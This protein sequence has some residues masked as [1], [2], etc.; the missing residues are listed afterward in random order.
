MI[1]QIRADNVSVDFKPNQIPHLSAKT[2]KVE[3]DFI[4]P[5]SQAAKRTYTYQL[6]GTR[7][8]LFG[9][10]LPLTIELKASEG[11]KATFF[12]LPPGRY[13]FQIKSYPTDRPF[14]LSSHGRVEFEIDGNF[15]EVLWGYLLALIVSLAAVFGFFLLFNRCPK[16]RENRQSLNV[17]EKYKTFKLSDTE[18]KHWLSILISYMEEEKP[19]LDQ[20]ITLPGLAEQLSVRKEVLSQAINRELKLNFNSFLNGYRIEEAKRKLKDPKENQFVIL[21]IAYEVGFNSKSSFNAVFKKMTGM[22]PKE[23][24]EKHQ[25]G[26][27]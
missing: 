6:E 17:D 15:Y 3:F 12:G 8:S 1:T 13:A 16:I 9:K 25:T 10:S 2:K 21:K 14:Q 23:Y 22:S 19:Y 7:Y 20:N 11:N 5:H 4:T 26:D 27:L 24:R 18:S